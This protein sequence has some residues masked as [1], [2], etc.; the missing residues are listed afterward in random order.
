MN[1]AY[2]SSYFKAYPA[3]KLCC[4]TVP[5]QILSLP[6]PF[7]A[8]LRHSEVGADKEPHWPHSESAS[9]HSHT[10]TGKSDLTD[11][12]VRELIPGPKWEK[13][14]SPDSGS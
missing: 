1:K 13:S 4:V 10:V 2:N 6:F 14:H 8:P 9:V 5:V 3:F 11:G 12:S 7:S